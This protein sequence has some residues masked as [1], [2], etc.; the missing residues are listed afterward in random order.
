[1]ELGGASNGRIRRFQVGGCVGFS[2]SLPLKV[3]G[4]SF[5]NFC[6]CEGT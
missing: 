6:M 1:M 2:R 3:S 4:R 5:E